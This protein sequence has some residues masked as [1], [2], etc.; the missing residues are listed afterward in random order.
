MA[1]PQL[2]MMMLA[3]MLA[4]VG[5]A[6]AAVAGCVEGRGELYRG[7]ESTTAGSARCLNW[8]AVVGRDYDTQRH[9]DGDTGVGD[10]NFCRNPD[11][12]PRPWCYVAPVGGAGSPVEGGSPGDVGGGSPGPHRAYCS[13]TP[14]TGDGGTSRVEVE[15]SPPP[16][17][18]SSWAPRT[19]GPPILRDPTTAS[20]VGGQ[21]SY[22]PTT[23][24]GGLVSVSGGPPPPRLSPV[25]PDAQRSSAGSRGQKKDLGMMGHVIGISMMVIILLA[26][27]GISFMYIR[28]R[29]KSAQKQQQ[30]KAQEREMR[31]LNGGPACF[32]NPACCSSSGNGGSIIIVNDLGCYSPAPLQ[33]LQS[34]QPPQPPQPRRH[35]G[36]VPL[37]GGESSPG[38]GDDDDV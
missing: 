7:T 32:E 12:A 36:C 30:L 6:A 14:C 5:Q 13:L 31:R 3:M 18:S 37:V 16:P 25:L 11:G 34:P 15:R 19:R 17:P 2:M 23:P 20:G 4:K 24:S 26:G 27:G 8:G 35:E 1:V 9:P 38:G 10:H 29:V 28:K 22:S 21:A 33:S